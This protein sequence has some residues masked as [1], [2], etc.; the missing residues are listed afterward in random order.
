MI[1]F[2]KLFTQESQEYLTLVENYPYPRESYKSH[3][4]HKAPMC[5]IVQELSPWDQPPLQFRSKL[6]H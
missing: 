2:V 3:S 5:P 6:I 1:M 4:S